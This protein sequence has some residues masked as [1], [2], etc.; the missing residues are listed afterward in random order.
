MRLVAVLVVSL[1]VAQVVAYWQPLRDWYSVGKRGP[2]WF[3]SEA[4]WSPPIPSLLRI[5]R[6]ISWG[7]FS[8]L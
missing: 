5:R 3:F 4:I 1:A 2:F 6:R 7:W 8:S